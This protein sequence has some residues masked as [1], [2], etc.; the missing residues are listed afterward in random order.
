MAA[1]RVKNL[2]S[3]HEDEGLIL[4]LPQW[5]KGSSVA[6]SCSVDR[7]QMW[8]GSCI[9]LAVAVAVAANC[10]SDLISS[11]GTSICCRCG[12]KKTKTDRQTDRQTETERNKEEFPS[13]L[14][15]N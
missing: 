8:L 14:S 11:L 4:C 2:T 6:A 7:W 10:S 3:I 12:P 15:G 9:A 5:V 1:Q 13:W